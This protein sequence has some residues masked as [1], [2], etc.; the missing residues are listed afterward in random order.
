L[1]SEK[2]IHFGGNITSKKEKP[3]SST[4]PGGIRLKM[5]GNLTRSGPRESGKRGFRFR[6][7]GRKRNIRSNR[8]SRGRPAR[9]KDA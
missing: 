8:K 4:A 7:S 5:K 3:G 1:G 2:K 6:I 9:K